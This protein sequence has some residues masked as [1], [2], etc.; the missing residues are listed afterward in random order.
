VL[1]PAIFGSAAIVASFLVLTV[2]QGFQSLVSDALV[3]CFGR[4]GQFGVLLALPITAILTWYC[5]DYLTPTMPPLAIGSGP[6]WAPFQHGITLQRYL[7]AL[8]FQTPV[9]LFSVCYCGA[10]IR[11]ISKESVVLTGFIFAVVVGV[12]LGS[13]TAVSVFSHYTGRH[14]WSY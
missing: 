13:L 11:Q 1:V 10:A 2:P 14:F 3:C 5:Y 8:I 7:G 4:R 12:V 9:T 6:D